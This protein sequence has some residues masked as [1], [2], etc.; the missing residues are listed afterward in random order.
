[1]IIEGKL[2]NGVTTIFEHLPYVQS[3]AIGIWV[4][5]G[6]VDERQP[7]T[8]G[9]ADGNAEKI[10]GGISHYIEHMMFKG[11]RNRSAKQIA[12]DIDKIGGS[13]NAFTGREATCYYV[14]TLTENLQG[15]VDVLADMFNASLFDPIE[16]EKE[17]NVIIEEM[18]MIEDSPEDFGQDLI[19]ET[20]FNGASLG[21]SVIGTRESVSDVKRQ[22]ILDYMSER[23]TAENLLISVAGNFDEKGLPEMLERGFGRIAPG[24]KPRK[25]I[26]AP[27][28]PTSVRKTKDI[29]Q[30]HLF[31]GCRGI[32]QE[33]DDYYT[34]LLYN[35][36][37]GGGMS[38]RLFQNV[39]EEKGLAYSVYSMNSSFVDDGEFVIY[40][41]VGN[42]NEP[43]ATE[44]I[45]FEVEQLAQEGADEDELEKVKAQNKGHFIFGQESISSR[46]F[47]MGR[48]RLLLGRV[49][50]DAEVTAGIDKVTCADIVRI[51]AAYQ[52]MA[53]YSSVIICGEQR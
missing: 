32:R 18:K 31:F 6:A 13:I 8:G 5:A 15:S 17:K 39:R 7:S 36:I 40:A 50:S 2:S 3:A 48:N 33:S 26:L 51:A 49:L 38:S 16:M 1:M 29:E 28:A 9:T 37:L 19:G 21:H 25:S 10:N 11:T 35:S 44:A 53:A 22:D 34:F 4:K 27:H 43:A 24:G 46:M 52:D 20:V 14:K 42:E 47:R 12:E 45:R 23:Y 41:G 30:T